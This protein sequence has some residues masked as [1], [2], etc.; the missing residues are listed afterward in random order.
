MMIGDSFDLRF[1]VFAAGD[2]VI[3]QQTS[4]NGGTLS[5]VSS[6][7]TTFMILNL[8]GQY[9]SADFSAASDSQN[10]T[11]ISLNNLSP[12]GNPPP[13][14]GTTADMIMSD[15]NNGVR[16]I[17]DIGSNAVLAAYP[18]GQLARIGTVA[19][20][21]RFKGSDTT[22]MILRDSS[23]GAFEVYDISNNNITNAA[24]WVRSG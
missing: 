14:A 11:L 4:A 18:L 12:A 8:A 16:E 13:P 1:Q 22:D 3:W 24:G 5:L 10:G 9:T 6:S 17:Y 7:G 23:S 21:G 19:G 2:Q 15:G 20:L